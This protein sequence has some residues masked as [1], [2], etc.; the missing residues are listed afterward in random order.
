M[1]V[2]AVP[3]LF[4]ESVADIYTAACVAPNGAPK[5]VVEA[6]ALENDEDVN[7]PAGTIAATLE[8]VV[9]TVESV[10][11]VALAPNTTL[12]AE[13]VAPR[14]RIAIPLVDPEAIEKV[15]MYE[16]AAVAE[17]VNVEPLR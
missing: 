7:T 6:A 3:T 1:Q 16:Q 10:S 8:D 9:V 12:V 11:V 17:R 4:V 15:H 5:T 14:E 2:A 13:D